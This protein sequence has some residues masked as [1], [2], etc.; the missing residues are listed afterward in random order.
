MAIKATI[1]ERGNVRLEGV[2]L[3]PEVYA[4][5]MEINER[6]GLNWAD[7]INA[8]IMTL[9]EISKVAT[10]QGKPLRKAYDG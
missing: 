9:N 1:V 8:A 10:A 7:A 3:M 4:A 5:L 2:Q 6:D